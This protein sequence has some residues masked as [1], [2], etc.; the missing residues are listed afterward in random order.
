MW[1]KAAREIAHGGT[2]FPAQDHTDLVLV[3]RAGKRAA[4]TNTP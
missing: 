3:S 1:L 4:A 2:R